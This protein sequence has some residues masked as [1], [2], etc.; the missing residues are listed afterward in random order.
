MPTS[1]GPAALLEVSAACDVLAGQL[2]AVI[3][4]DQ[5]ELAADVVA[6]VVS[7]ELFACAQDMA[8]LFAPLSADEREALRSV[9][10]EMGDA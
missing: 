7:I 4:R 10:A 1:E 3:C 5:P 9:L 6:E 2:T 8:R